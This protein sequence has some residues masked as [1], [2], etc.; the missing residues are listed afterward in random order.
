MRI[1]GVAGLVVMLVLPLLGFSIAEADPYHEHI[2]VG[3][4]AAEQLSALTHHL[5]HHAASPWLP[6]TRSPQTNGMDPA[7]VA[8]GFCVVSVLSSGAV[9]A[10]VFALG[11]A[12]LVGIGRC[13]APVPTLA[14]RI[15][16]VPSAFWWEV[17]VLTPDPPPRWS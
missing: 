9:G 12:G 17:N 4:T 1:V 16:M 5:Y 13:V 6:P 11:G 15:V 14:G 7:A 10:A 2:L 3:G 8:G